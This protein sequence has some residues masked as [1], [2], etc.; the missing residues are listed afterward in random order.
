[1]AKHLVTDEDIL[2][3]LYWKIETPLETDPIDELILVLDWDGREEDILK[4]FDHF[5]PKNPR[6]CTKLQQLFY[7]LEG[8][9]PDSFARWV[10]ENEEWSLLELLHKENRV[11]KNL[12]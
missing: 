1:L 9:V 8:N 2:Q 10:I 12:L 7:V 6:N 4:L 5:V 11:P 3:I